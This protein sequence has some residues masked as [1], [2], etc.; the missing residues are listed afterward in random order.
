M[1]GYA[2]DSFVILSRRMGGGGGGGVVVS[3]A[4]AKR[5]GSELGVALPQG[6]S[7]LENRARCQALLGRG[8]KG[9]LGLSY[10]SR[11]ILFLVLFLDKT[12]SVG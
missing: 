6:G 10:D 3:R 9:V 8:P 11:S 7:L 5:G 12:I 2:N 1:S 4:A